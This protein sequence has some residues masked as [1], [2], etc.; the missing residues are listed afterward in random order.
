MTGFAFAIPG[1][2][3]LPTGGYAYDRRVIAE[4]RLA[5]CDVTHVALSGGFPYPTPEDLVACR[6]RLEALPAGQALLIDGLAMGALPAELLRGLGRPIAALVHHPLALE[7]GLDDRRHAQ[8]MA[9]ERAA[10]ALAC[11]VIATS[12]STARLLEQDYGVARDRLVVA[13]P[14]TDPRPRA[15]GTGSPTRLLSVGAVIPRKAHGVLVEA[16][17]SLSSLDW[18]CRIVGA[19]DRDVEETRRLRRRIALHGLSDRVVLTG[20]ISREALGREFEAADIFVSASLFEG[21]GMALTEALA[22]G[23]P[24]VATSGGAIPDTVPSA[25]SVLVAPNDAAALAEG[26][27]SLLRDPDHRRAL[28]QRA[29]QYA[30]SLPDWSRTAAT[31]MTALRE[32]AR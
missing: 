14:G 9:S 18:T 17:A 1:D 29:W 32:M 28:G 4:C 6:G 10:L 26:I 24:V 25:A 15:R 11:A 2:I 30:A 20:A 12:P 13:L 5:G 31:I 22:H 7:T 23:L 21:Y 3:D 19:T 16:L 27:G 8:L